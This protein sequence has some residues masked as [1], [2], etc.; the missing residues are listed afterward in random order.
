LLGAGGERPGWTVWGN[1]ADETYKP[2][3]ATYAYNS[4]AAE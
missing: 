4:V 1:Q 2:T 3:W